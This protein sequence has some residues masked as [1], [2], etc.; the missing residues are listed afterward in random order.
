MLIGFGANNI[1][2]CNLDDPIEIKPITILMG[3]NSSGK[4]S[5]LQAMSLLTMNKI[6]GNDIKRIKY[7]FSDKT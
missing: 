3:Q 5:F 2:A 7:N 6:L 4:T 1:K